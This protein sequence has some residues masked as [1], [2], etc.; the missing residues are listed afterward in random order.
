MKLSII[1]HANILVAHVTRGL[2]RDFRE[3]FAQIKDCMWSHV[4][5]SGSEQGAPVEIASEYEA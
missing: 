1:M 2:S 4:M 3:I 5:L